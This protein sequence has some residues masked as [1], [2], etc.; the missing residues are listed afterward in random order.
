[1]GVS[2]CLLGQAV[3]YDGAS[4]AHAWIQQELP[5]RAEIVSL[6]PE[7]GAGLE[8]PRPAVQLTQ[9]EKGVRALGVENPAL[10]VTDVLL[11]WAARQAALLETL[12][13]LILKSRS[14][15]CAVHSAPVFDAQGEITKHRHG[16]FTAWVA[17]HFPHLPLL[18]ECSAPSWFNS[19]VGRISDSAIRQQASKRK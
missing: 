17:R 1:M 8:I 5:G 3:R 15:S 7:V 13:A 9:T 19:S 6:C 18:D 4:K 12:D 2:A 10:D 11:D 16:L 14:P